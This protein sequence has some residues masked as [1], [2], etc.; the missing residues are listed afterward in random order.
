MNSRSLRFHWR[1]PHGGELDSTPL[2]AQR[3]STAIG[4]PDLERQT[5]FCRQAEKYGIDSLLTDF[6]SAKPDSLL[7]ATALG[8]ATER[9]KFIV[10]YRSGLLSP[11]TF[12]QQINT[13]SALINGRL[14]LNIVAGFSP[15]EQHGYG[16][17][18]SHDERYKRT[19]EFLAVC[20]SFWKSK[21]PVTF[22]GKYYKLEHGQ[23]GT[24]FISNG[25][26]APEIFIAG[27]SAAARRLAQRRATCWLRFADTPE[28]IRAESF[29]GSEE[30]L[31]LAI[32]LSVITRPTRAEALRA[33]TALVAN[34]KN[35]AGEKHFIR[36]TDSWSIQT[37]YD[38]ADNEWLNDYLWTGAVRYIGPTALALVGTPEEVASAL[39]EYRKVGVTQFILSG[40]P[41][42]DE[43]IRFGR[44]VLP[45]IRKK[46]ADYR[47]NS[48]AINSRQESV[49]NVA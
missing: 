8:L 34:Y 36:N 41:K 32:R 44:D 37:T 12:V 14:S 18:L 35:N 25:R 29:I 20:M 1:L 43:M 16:D 21:A 39:M 47:Q 40:W 19:D 28:K 26:T 13:L 11:A 5:H 49:T 15:Q 45:L 30:E 22:S 23:L 2:S 33:A 24:P 27:S 4:L 7:L 10:A 46:E 6:G 9:I 38:L 17:F 31:D 3:H 42:L 48:S